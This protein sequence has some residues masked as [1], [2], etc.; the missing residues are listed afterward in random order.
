[1]QNNER[2]KKNSIL[3]TKFEPVVFTHCFDF[4]VKKFFFFEE[5]NNSFRN[6]C[7]VVFLYFH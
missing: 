2:E 5:Q 4:D 6:A 7:L 3:R 1:M